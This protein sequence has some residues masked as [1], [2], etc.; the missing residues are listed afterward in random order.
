MMQ[1]AG[2]CN[3]IILSCNGSGT[4]GESVQPNL[5]GWSFLFRTCFTNFGHSNSKIYQTIYPPSHAPY[6]LRV[7]E[8]GTA[9][10]L[11][12]VQGSNRIKSLGGSPVTHQPTL[13][14]PLTFLTSKM[15]SKTFFVVAAFVA[16]ALA[17]EYVLFLHHHLQVC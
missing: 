16:G 8:N 15:F 5:V 11:E 10:I 4:S 9:T 1:N 14:I 3:S 17:T 12:G 6:L 13:L 7:R 2:K